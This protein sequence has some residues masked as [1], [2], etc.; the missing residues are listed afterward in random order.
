[1]ICLSSVGHSLCIRS[2]TALLS[3]SQWEHHAPPQP[4]SERESTLPHYCCRCC[5]PVL[6]GALHPLGGRGLST[7]WFS[8]TEHTAI[9]SICPIFSSAG[10][11]QHSSHHH[12]ITIGLHQ[13]DR[14]TAIIIRRH[15]A[16][17]PLPLRAGQHHC[18]FGVTPQTTTQT[19][20]PPAMVAVLCA[21]VVATGLALTPLRED[22]HNQ[23]CR[24][25]VGQAQGLLASQS[26]G[27]VGLCGCCGTLA[28]VHL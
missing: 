3:C 8:S 25:W 7:P 18:H 12:S 9:A 14:Q 4:S 26:T 6:F 17:M 27:C 22:Y 1:M 2:H 11:H 23:H 24:C 10:Q 16:T 5:L 19:P 21:A 28:Q 15:Q 13:E 20:T